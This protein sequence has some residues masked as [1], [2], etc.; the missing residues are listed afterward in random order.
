MANKTMYDDDDKLVILTAAPENKNAVT[1]AEATNVA[2]IDISMQIRANPTLGATGSEKVN[3]PAMG[4]SSASETFGK[5]GA[6]GQLEAFLYYDENGQIDPVTST[7]YEA[8]NG[9]GTEVWL[10]RR[11]G[12]KPAS[13]ALAAGD[14]YSI[15][16]VVCDDPQPPSDKTG[17]V[18]VV[19][20]LAVA[21]MAIEK[22][23]VADES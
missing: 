14:T 17:W 16:K 10:L 9:K 20:P 22:V 23:I 4:E 3:M 8:L 12:G 11:T 15:F 19:I 2:N 18:R 6:A 7:A 13:A 1:V 5:S 21:D